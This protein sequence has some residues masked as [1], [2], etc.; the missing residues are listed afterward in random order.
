MIWEP[1][2]AEILYAHLIAYGEEMGTLA[3]VPQNKVYS[4]DGDTRNIWRQAIR[5]RKKYVEGT[6]TKELIDCFEKYELW[7]GLE[8]N[9]SNGLTK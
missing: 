8:Q 1:R 6:L 4:I 9:I 2:K 5:L 7:H 3:D